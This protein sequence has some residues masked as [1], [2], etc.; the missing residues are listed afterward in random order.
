M[1][2]N[3]SDERRSFLKTVVLLSGAAASVPLIAG[4]KTRGKP[5]LLAPEK[6]GQGYRETEHVRK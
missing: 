4:A 1:A 5:D 2:K 3:Y 6:S